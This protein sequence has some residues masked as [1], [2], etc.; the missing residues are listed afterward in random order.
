MHYIMIPTVILSIWLVSFTTLNNGTIFSPAAIAMALG[1]THSAQNPFHI[2]GTHEALHYV[3][4]LKKLVGSLT[5]I[6]SASWYVGH[7]ICKKFPLC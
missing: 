7:G 5:Y 2:V 6:H 1:Y 3:N 4:E